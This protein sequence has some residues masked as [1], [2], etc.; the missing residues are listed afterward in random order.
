MNL[1]KRPPHEGFYVYSSCA[2]GE[3]MA[4]RLAHVQEF[5]KTL[6]LCVS[7]QEAIELAELIISVAKDYM[8]GIETGIE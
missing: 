7:P 4:I 8:A 3:E 2:C 1:Y 6:E 5:E